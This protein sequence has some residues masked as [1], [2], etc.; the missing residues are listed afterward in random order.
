ML[1]VGRNCRGRATRK[2]SRQVS[3]NIMKKEAPI[4]GGL[5]VEYSDWSAKWF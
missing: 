5:F 3:W 2:Q 4:V 1:S